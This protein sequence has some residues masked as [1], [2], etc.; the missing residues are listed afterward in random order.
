MAMYVAVLLGMGISTLLSLVFIELCR[1]SALKYGIVDAPISEVK[2]HRTPTPYLGGVGIVLAATVTY[3]IVGTISGSSS[4]QGLLIL[5]GGMV[6]LVLGL[7]DDLRPLSPLGKLC[8]QVAIAL[9]T[10]VSG[11]VIRWTGL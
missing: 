5:L 11:L 2:T 4:P 8:G 3:L 9:G 1:V 10:I 6:A 7:W